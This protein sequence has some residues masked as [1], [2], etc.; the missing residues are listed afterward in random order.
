MSLDLK[1][2]L[3]PNIKEKAKQF[4]SDHKNKKTPLTMASTVMTTSTTDGNHRDLTDKN[5]Q[6]Q[7]DETINISKMVDE[8]RDRQFQTI[9]PA[10]ESPLKSN[11]AIKVK[12]KYQK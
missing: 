7:T 5:F 9:S 10:I 6:F 4:F 12:I 3:S 8:T 1:K 2:M 11:L